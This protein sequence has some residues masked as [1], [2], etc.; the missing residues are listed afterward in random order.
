MLYIV[1][2]DG[3]AR[4]IRWLTVQAGIVGPWSTATKLLDFFGLPDGRSGIRRSDGVHHT[5][6]VDY[7]CVRMCVCVWCG[8]HWSHFRVWRN[9][10]CRLTIA[11]K[12][13]C[14]KPC[15]QQHDLHAFRSSHLDT[16][17]CNA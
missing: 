12:A 10:T 3:A 1:E 11:S 9:V 5:A 13:M 17:G 15:A 16:K 7:G 4:R 8:G 6:E 2:D 14:K